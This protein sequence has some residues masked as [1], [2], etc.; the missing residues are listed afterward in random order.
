MTS[1]SKSA[2][3]RAIAALGPLLLAQACSVYSDSLLEGLA[4]A[5]SMAASPGG[6]G[7]AKSSG[8]GASQTQAGGVGGLISVAG[9]SGSGD[10]SLAGGTST[11]GTFAGTLGDGGS[12]GTPAAE[13]ELI[14]DMEDS[15][16]QVSLVGGRDGFWYVGNDGTADGMQTPPPGAFAMFELEVDERPGSAFAAHMDVKGFTGWGSVMG[17]NLDEQGSTVVAFDASSYCGLRFSGKASGP[18]SSRLEFPNA[19]TGPA[20]KAC[21]QTGPANQL[22]FDHFTVPLMFTAAWKEYTVLF[23]A[24]TQLGSGYRPADKKF[25]S[26]ALFAVQWIMGKGSPAGKQAALW[27][28]DVEFL[29]PPVGGSCE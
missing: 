20:G 1:G 25:K 2:K 19:D 10:A 24:L 6:A 23:S 3:C 28:D 27:V 9:L 15:D 12:G 4:S 13:T 11:A 14:D 16:G 8:S 26:Q 18:S 5:G 29:K 21:S 22:C 17:F 7:G